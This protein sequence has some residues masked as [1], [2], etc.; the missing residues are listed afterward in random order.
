MVE[1]KQ[2]REI[3]GSECMWDETSGSSCKKTS[4]M[5]RRERLL[6]SKSLADTLARRF[7]FV[8]GD[9]DSDFR[10]RQRRSC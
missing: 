1:E 9:V 4:M 8:M 2:E 10:V 7:F 3:T 5:K 6:A